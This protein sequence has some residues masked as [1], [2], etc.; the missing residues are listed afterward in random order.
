MMETYQK[1][2]IAYLI[3]LL[4]L[5]VFNCLNLSDNHQSILNVYS[6]FMI[7]QFSYSDYNFRIKSFLTAYARNKIARVAM[8]D[9]K[10]VI[11]I[12]TD[13]CVFTKKQK[14]YDR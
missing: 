5:Q 3:Y 1:C 6:L 14:F 2:Y 10:S 11:R 7:C 13:C 12:Q 4:F 8:T 9:L